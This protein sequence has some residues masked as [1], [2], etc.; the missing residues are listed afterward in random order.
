MLELMS[1]ESLS[2]S[3]QRRREVALQT[4]HASRASEGSFRR[5]MGRLL[6]AIGRRVAGKTQADI[7]VGYT[8]AD[9]IDA[10][11]QPQVTAWAA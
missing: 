2:V 1:L 4:M 5:V 8:N 6:V 10:E 11:P 9:C 3:E 7:L